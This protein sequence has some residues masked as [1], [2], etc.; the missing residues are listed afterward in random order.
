MESSIKGKVM[1][2]KET[3]GKGSTDALNTTI[4]LP[5]RLGTFALDL[6]IL[7]PFPFFWGT[8]CRDTFDGF[9]YD[10]VFGFA[11]QFLFPCCNF[12]F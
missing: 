5:A 7:N 9:W 6:I 4:P 11:P 1:M 10:I 2:R 8:I 3:Q 12:F